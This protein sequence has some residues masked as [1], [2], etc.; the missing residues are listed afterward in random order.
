M[1]ST[2][3]K[4]A[5]AEAAKETTAIS[6]VYATTFEVL[7]ASKTACR[8][9]SSLREVKAFAISPNEA[10]LTF[11]SASKQSE[12]VFF[13]P[14][15]AKFSAFLPEDADFAGPESTPI[16]RCKGFVLFGEL[17][18]GGLDIVELPTDVEWFDCATV[19]MTQFYS[20]SDDQAKAVR[21]QY[22]C[23][24]AGNLRKGD[25]GA[26]WNGIAKRYDDIPLDKLYRFLNKKKAPGKFAYLCAGVN[27]EKELKMGSLGSKKV[28]NRS[29]EAFPFLDGPALLVVDSD[30][31][32][33]WS[34]LRSA[35][36]VREV[37]ARLGLDA[38]CVTS[39][40]AS[41]YVTYPNG[42]H[43]L[44][45]LHTFFAIDQGTQIPR[46]LEIIHKRAWL[47][48][49]GR[50]LVGDNG[51]L[52]VR[53]VVDLAMK[54]PNQPIFEY[55]AVIHDPRITQ[56]RQVKLHLGERRKI[57]AA[58]L[59]DLS[60]DEEAE[61]LRLVTDAK[62]DL[63]LRAAEQT[64]IW[65]DRQTASLPE[66]ERAAARA[67]LMALRERKHRDLPPYFQIV[68]NDGQRVA[69]SKILAEP[70]KWSR[71]SIRDPFEPE[72]GASKATVF[73][74]GQDD[75]RPKIISQAHGDTTVY[76]LDA[77]QQ[78]KKAIP[79][80]GV[81]S[82]DMVLREIAKRLG[83]LDD[84]ETLADELEFE[85]EK[86]N[87]VMGVI[88]HN[89]NNSKFILMTP[90][91]GI[92][93]SREQDLQMMVREHYGRFM[94]NPRI[95]VERA[96][97][98][99]NW[100][101][102][103]VLKVVKEIEKKPY[104]F[105]A[106]KAKAHRQVTKFDIDVDMFAT[107]GSVRYG[108]GVAE[109]V[110]PHEPFKV[111]AID[112]AVI[113]DYKNHFPEFDD[114]I[115]L[116][117]ASRFASSRKKA[118]L[119]LNCD[120]DWGKSF[121]MGALDRLGLVVETSVGELA[122]M[123]E[124]GPVGKTIEDFKR[125]WCVAIDE[126]KGVTRE[127]KQMSEY[128]NFAPKGLATVR[129]PLYLKLFMSA[130]SVDSLASKDSGIEDQFANRFL[131]LSGKG[132]IEN[133]A[134]FMESKGRYLT[135]LASYIAQRLNERVDYFRLLGAVTAADAADDELATIYEKY[136]IDRKFDRLST[137]LQQIARD[138]AEDCAEA[139][140]VHQRHGRGTKFQREAGPYVF[141]TP[142]H[143]LCLSHPVTVLNLWI[144]DTYGRSEGGKLGYKKEQI[145]DALGGAK[146]IAGYG[147][148]RKKGVVLGVSAPDGAADDGFND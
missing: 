124:G 144:E 139:F 145:I 19:A 131:Y 5:P 71:R 120:S 90:S 59:P 8:L 114:F 108:D 29:K 128:I 24:E 148:D 95:V 92:V 44:R 137:K 2:N 25:V 56:D 146:T 101:A 6:D 133:R 26:Y 46:V 80:W 142:S 11:E 88:T 53:S 61:F 117:A 41:S 3:K 121:L 102:A 14:A 69:V 89:S 43:R 27:S 28:Q 140:A 130:E 31:L 70:D 22:S 85:G 45:G 39:S 99:A 111:D 32:G 7:S 36:A 136:R 12:K 75:G 64:E 62:A 63:Q 37:L 94:A 68:T 118:H 83:R 84:L 96:A 141:D 9:P 127:V 104:E 57:V 86:I 119:W 115:D 98:E 110:F 147:N 18:A 126:F 66:E 52:H 58:E 112:E 72:Y 143:G 1:D 105:I 48:G 138:F 91:S 77:R 73:T 60:A 113:F 82:G 79:D 100:N 38:D 42:R 125:I 55:G 21:K 103:T 129:A 132:S 97:E 74:K 93:Y 33:T 30:E 51:V 10:L 47:A 123:L 23:D 4:A 16:C 134:L 67:S 17:V 49:Y 122:K 116:L 106:A 13:T 135:S 34:N 76:F 78:H 81:V 109:M 87:Q 65:L 20:E 54:T 40:S 107:M 50:I 15:A 35:E